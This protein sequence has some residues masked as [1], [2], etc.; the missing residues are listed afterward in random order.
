MGCPLRARRFHEL[1]ASCW[2]ED[3]EPDLAGAVVVIETDRGAVGKGAGCGRVPR[4]R[5]Q[6]QAG[7]PAQGD[8]RGVGEG[9]RLLRCCRPG[10]HGPNPPTLILR[11]STP[12]AGGGELAA[13]VLP[14][15][16]VPFAQRIRD[17]LIARISEAEREGWPGEIEELKI[18]LAGAGDKLAQID[19][20][21]AP[22]TRVRP[23]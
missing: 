6:S 9:G 23:T 18:S 3:G 22:A 1:V 7:R 5:G 12:P 17:N 20:R 14:A 2:G 15:P 8:D 16:V 10:G 21:P 19:R 11:S 13:D 4:V